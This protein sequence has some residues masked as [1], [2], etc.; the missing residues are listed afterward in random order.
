MV[1]SS[2]TKHWDGQFLTAPSW[3]ALAALPEHQRDQRILITMAGLAEKPP[4]QRASALRLLI[5]AELELDDA[6]LE[7]LT[8]GRCRAWASLEDAEAREFL[9]DVLAVE[10]RFIAGPDA[11]RIRRAYAQAAEDLSAE[12]VARFERVVPMFL[13]REGRRSKR[14]VKTEVRS[15]GMLR[16]LFGRS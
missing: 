11:T 13:H 12:D 1:Q 9:N 4:L 8:L 6:S 15:G 5:S 3:T 7:K 10:Y 2:L 16:R 14:R